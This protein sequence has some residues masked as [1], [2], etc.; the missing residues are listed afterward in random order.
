VEQ[1]MKR[2]HGLQSGRG[3]IS[4]STTIAHRALA[5]QGVSDSLL[6]ALRRAAALEHDDPLVNELGALHLS[7]VRQRHSL[8][9]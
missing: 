5:L 1:F 4:S 9:R 2:L 6:E 7:V 3:R 8:D